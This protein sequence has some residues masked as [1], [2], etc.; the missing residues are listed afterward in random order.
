MGVWECWLTQAVL[1]GSLAVFWQ[2]R[3]KLEASQ[4][5]QRCQ[6]H[7]STC[8][9]ESVEQGCGAERQCTALLKEIVELFYWFVNPVYYL[10]PP[11]LFIAPLRLK[12]E[13]RSLDTGASKMPCWMWGWGPELWCVLETHCPSVIALGWSFDSPELGW[14]QLGA[15]SKMVFILV[16]LKCNLWNHSDGLKF[17]SLCNRLRRA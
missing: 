12:N 17:L 10:R 16:S 9:Y 14:E 5:L 3:G 13:L 11:G 4:V 2:K 15:C 7:L 6:N 1:F 8:K